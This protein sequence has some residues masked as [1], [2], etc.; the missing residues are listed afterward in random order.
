MSSRT[1]NASICQPGCP[2]LKAVREF[3]VA[4][5]RVVDLFCGAVT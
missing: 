4:A 5:P 3:K 2:D 1:R